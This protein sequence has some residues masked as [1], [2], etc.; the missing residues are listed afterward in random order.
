MSELYH[1]L[2]K[3]QHIIQEETLKRNR[4]TLWADY[5]D[6]SNPDNSTNTGW[7]IGKQ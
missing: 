4:E 7:Y 6:F 1:K 3:Q 2:K 5:S